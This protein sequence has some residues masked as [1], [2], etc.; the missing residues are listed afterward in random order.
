M[1]QSAL[2]I[3]PTPIGNLKDITLRAIEILKQSTM[4]AA[5]DTRHSRLLLEHYE[6]K[7]PKLISCHNFNE[8]QRVELIATEIE[9]GGVVSLI[10]DAG[11]PLICDPGFKLVRALCE[12]GITVTALPGPCA[13]ITALSLSGLPTDEF[14]FKGFLPVKEQELKERLKE[15]AGMNMP[16][17]CYEAPHRILTAARLIREILS[18]HPVV[19]ARELTKTFET[20]YRVKGRDL[21]E[22]LQEAPNSTKGEFVLMIGPGHDEEQGEEELDPIVLRALSDLCAAAP[23]KLVAKSLSAVTKIRANVLYEA[24]LKLKKP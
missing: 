7:P 1:P 6:I 24:A 22:R 16:V 14:C 4:V 23:V 10:S 2:Y 3:V 5:E 13:A 8:E 21:L 12:R 17:V 18:D 15:I 20:V 11:T 19:L 9:N